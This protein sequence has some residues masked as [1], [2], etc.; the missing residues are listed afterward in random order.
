MGAHTARR[1]RTMGVAAT[2]AHLSAVADGPGAS[3]ARSKKRWLGFLLVAV[4]LGALLFAS[5]AVPVF[6]AGS[7]TLVDNGFESG[8]DGATLANPPW[9]GVAGAPQHR[10]YDN[11]RAKVG[12]QSAWI[13]GPAAASNGGRAL[14]PSG[15]GT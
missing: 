15:L 5:S 9:A 6:A 12:A 4:L 8:A 11:A 14:D 3:R 7:G 2:N 13:Q 1:P 10:E